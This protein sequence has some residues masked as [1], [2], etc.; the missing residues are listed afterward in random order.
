MGTQYEVENGVVFDVPH[1]A[2]LSSGVDQI[3]GVTTP[4]VITYD[5]QDAI[6]GLIHSTSVN[7]GEIEVAEDGLYLICPQP[8]IGKDSGGTGIIFDMFMQVDRGSG[9]VDE[10]N[11][12]IKETVKDADITDVVVMIVNIVLNAGDKIRFLQRV[13]ATGVGMGLKFT[14]SEVGP[15]TVPATPSIIFTMA[16]NA[17]GR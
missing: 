5:T 14:A 11:T 16:R 4:I 7:P 12:N 3:P 8:Q 13:S 15:P 10:P 9:F 2:Q 1:F 17:G 6:Q